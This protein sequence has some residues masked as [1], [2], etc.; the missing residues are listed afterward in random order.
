MTPPDSSDDDKALW[1][2][3][4]RDVKKLPSSHK[5]T[6]RISF[7]NPER[8]KPRIIPDAPA[9]S[10]PSVG[11]GLDR[12]T[13]QRFQKGRMKIEARLDLHGMT[14][15]DA[16]PAVRN[17][18]I[19]HYASGKRCVLIITGKGSG[20]Y[21]NNKTEDLWFDPGPGGIRRNFM[22]WLDAPDLKPLILSVSPAQAPH[23]GTGAF[24][25][26]LRRHRSSGSCPE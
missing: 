4:M 18:I 19:R 21:K 26:L 13:E 17:F 2:R 3:A 1:Q 14:L 15:A 7:K 20:S 10:P 9:L 8:R 25:V 22:G 6:D 16:Q 23:G 12:R 5:E 11:N 24:Y